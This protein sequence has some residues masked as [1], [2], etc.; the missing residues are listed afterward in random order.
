MGIS[1]TAPLP[2]RRQTQSLPTMLRSQNNR[3]IR[4][5]SKAPG[6]FPSSRRLTGIFTGIAFSP[7]CS[8]RQFSSRY[9]FHAGLNLPGKGLRYFN[10]VI[11][12][13]DVHWGFGHSPRCTAAEIPI[14]NGHWSLVIPDAV[15]RSGT[16]NTPAL[17]RRRPLYILF[18]S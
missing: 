9:A 5:Y 7:G 15:H 12:T 3:T 14:S 13:A 16:V 17:V 4:S 2:P 10:T 11:V 1:L 6:V 8:W 18:W